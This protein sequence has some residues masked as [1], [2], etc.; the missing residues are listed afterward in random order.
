MLCL[1]RPPTPDEALLPAGSQLVSVGVIQDLR[2]WVRGPC[3][4]KQGQS[5]AMGF[6]S[7]SACLKKE[8]RSL[9]LALSQPHSGR[10]L[11]AHVDLSF[12]TGPTQGPAGFAL[13]D[14]AEDRSWKDGGGLV[15]PNKPLPN[16]V[17]PSRVWGSPASQQG[18]LPHG[19]S[20]LLLC[21]LG[22]PEMEGEWGGVVYLPR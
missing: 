4:R 15:S 1:G 19:N 16:L 20:L 5:K 9:P 2:G 18:G 13:E 8:L 11:P 10:W 12:C 22:S 7:G 21:V 14:K 17:W 6:L 3:V